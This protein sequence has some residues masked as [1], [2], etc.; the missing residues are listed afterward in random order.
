MNALARDSKHFLLLDKITLTRS[1]VDEKFSAIDYLEFLQV[2]F[3][4]VLK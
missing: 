2:D 4:A 3:H 1:K